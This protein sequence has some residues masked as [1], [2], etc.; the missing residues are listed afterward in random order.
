[1]GEIGFMVLVLV[2]STNFGIRSSDGLESKC[3]DLAAS[4]DILE[5]LCYS[6]LVCCLK[7]FEIR[8][9]RRSSRWIIQRNEISMNLQ[10]QSLTDTLAADVLIKSLYSSPSARGPCDQ[11]IRS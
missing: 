2:L 9:I 1:M 5:K 3:L 10:I 7:E 11:T 8:R 4:C 6:L